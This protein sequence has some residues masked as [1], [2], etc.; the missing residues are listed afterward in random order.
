M[1]SYADSLSLRDARRVYFD[2]NQFPADGGYS[3]RWVKVKIG[4][5]PFAFPNTKGR[6]EAVRY[7][8]LHH[9]A[10]GYDT[11]F[12][13]EGEIGAWEV[14]TGCR[15]YVAA[16]WLNLIAMWIGC[17]IAPRRI[18]RAFVRGRHTRN[19]YGERFDDAL[20]ADSVGGVRGRLGLAHEA[21][22][23]AA[24]R[25]AFA[26]WALAAFAAYAF[27]SAVVL[28]PFVVLAVWLF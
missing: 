23:T 13:G 18:F 11:D 4:P 5:F 6:V 12:R 19:L 27:Q 21:T 28:A 20:L 10:T 25:A 16:W 22:S 14:A 24:D 26:G 7:H 2:A 9:V 1:P 15:G 8:D 3:A 17:M